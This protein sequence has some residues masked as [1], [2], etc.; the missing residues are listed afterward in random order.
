M[1]SPLFDT[2]YQVFIS[3]TKDTETMEKMFDKH[4]EKDEK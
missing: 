3:A 4:I 1:E 2:L